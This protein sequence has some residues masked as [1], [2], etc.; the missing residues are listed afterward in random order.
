MKRNTELRSKFEKEKVKQKLL[1]YLL[2]I[3]EVRAE[4]FIVIKSLIIWLSLNVL[5]DFG[6][7]FVQK[8]VGRR[9]LLLLLFGLFFVF[10]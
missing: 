6:D 4:K 3:C 1:T 8:F 5:A 10:T 7:G 9:L 2:Y